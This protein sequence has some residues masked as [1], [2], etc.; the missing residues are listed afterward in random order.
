MHIRLDLFQ[1]DTTR[2]ALLAFAL[3]ASLAVAAFNI[4]L[5]TSKA[6]RKKTCELAQVQLQVQS[7]LVFSVVEVVAGSVAGL[8]VLSQGLGQAEEPTRRGVLGFAFT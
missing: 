6:E 1:F 4:R 7:H 5:S 3:G 2:H 8:G